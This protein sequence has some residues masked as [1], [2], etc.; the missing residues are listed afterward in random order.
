[1]IDSAEDMAW[2]LSYQCKDVEDKGYQTAVLYGREDNPSRVDFYITSG[3]LIDTPIDLT[4]F[5]PM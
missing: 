5:R 2:L 3:P 4:W 1:M